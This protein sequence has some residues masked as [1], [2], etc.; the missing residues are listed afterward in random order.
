[1]Y[2]KL[3]IK[4]LSVNRASMVQKGQIIKTAEFRK[5]VKDI[6]LL[7]P[8]SLEIPENKISLHIIFGFSNKNADLDNPVKPFQDCLQKKYKFNDNK[9][10]F[11][12]VTKEITKKG[13]EFIKFRIEDFTDEPIS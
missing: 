10:Y 3:E 9:I 6:H 1:M 7:L 2:T 11:L 13:Q 8:P 5:Y 4:P 12:S